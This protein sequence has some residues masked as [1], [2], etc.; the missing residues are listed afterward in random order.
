MNYH[1]LEASPETVH[2]GYF[3]ASLKPVL[4]VDSG[5]SVV[6]DTVSGGLNELGCLDRLRP[7]HREIATSV[8]QGPGIS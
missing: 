7:G 5:D 4:S 6:I 8:P 1:S 2:W 3:D